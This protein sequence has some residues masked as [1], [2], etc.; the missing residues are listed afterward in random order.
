MD[1]VNL[2]ISLVSGA[3][4]GNITGAAMKEKNL[5]VLG[6]TIAG[7]LGGGA[8]GYI[9]Q[10]LD[11]LNKSGVADAVANGQFDIGSLIGNIASSGVGGALLT[12]IAGW[13]KYAVN[14]S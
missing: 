1:I 9:F 3:A 2:I 6:N 11:A 4:G 12:F 10:I 14:K 7:L 5:G 13:I 8:G